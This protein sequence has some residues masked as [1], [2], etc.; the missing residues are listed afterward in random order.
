[1][2][3]HF[4]NTHKYSNRDR[5]TRFVHRILRVLLLHACSFSFGQSTANIPIFVWA[6][7]M[8]TTNPLE[9]RH[10]KKNTWIALNTQILKLVDT[11]T[12][13]LVAFFELSPLTHI[14]L[15]RAKKNA[16]RWMKSSRHTNTSD[17]NIF[18]LH[19]DRFTLHF[20]LFHTF[21]LHVFERY[22]MKKLL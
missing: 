22:V 21:A 14:N 2:N 6:K 18:Q 3:L 20:S 15:W 13:E 4:S 16:L 19:C 10:G 11:T 1:M 9:N 12:I 8:S 17:V 5:G 7:N